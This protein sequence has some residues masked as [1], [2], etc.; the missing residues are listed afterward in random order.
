MAQEQ[1]SAHKGSSEPRTSAIR[2]HAR[3]AAHRQ[4]RHEHISE[5]QRQTSD[6]DRQ[7][8][9]GAMVTLASPSSRLDTLRRDAFQ[10]LALSQETAVQSKI[11]LLRV[12]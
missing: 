5:Y 6:Y 1:P 8:E 9:D 12:F 7:H 11:S 10:S 3:R 4:I 2:S